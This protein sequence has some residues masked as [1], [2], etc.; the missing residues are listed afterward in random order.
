MTSGNARPRTDEKTS[1]T[2]AIENGSAVRAEVAE[3][4][5]PR[6]AAEAADLAD[7]GTGVGRDTGELLGHAPMMSRSPEGRRL[8][9]RPE[10]EPAEALH[11]IAC[12]RHDPMTEV[13]VR[14]LEHGDQVGQQ[15]EPVG[16][17]D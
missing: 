3:Q 15:P 14:G 1:P 5:P 13:G 11:A 17:L 8:P 12:C 6:H 10:F 9:R 7:D 4:A 2:I 16:E